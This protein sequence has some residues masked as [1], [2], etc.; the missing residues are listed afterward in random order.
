[1]W[2][3]CVHSNYGKVIVIGRIIVA[4]ATEVVAEVAAVAQNITQCCGSSND[5][6]G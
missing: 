3:S 6:D 1:M 4:E 5:G 2:L